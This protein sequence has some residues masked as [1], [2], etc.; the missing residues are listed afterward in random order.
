[1]IQNV[2]RQQADVA[3]SREVE[4]TANISDEPINLE[5][6]PDLLNVALANLLQNAIQASHPGGRVDIGAQASDTDVQISISD[7]GT[8]IVPEH[9]E[10]IFNPFFTTKPDG[11]GLGLAIV[12]K[13]IDEHQGRI[14]VESVKGS[15]TTF[16]I[17]LPKVQAA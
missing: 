7:Q 14:S 15:G 6:D 1:V 4:V 16:L 12:S 8:G 3:R 11:V 13:I 5:C 17:R 9:L 2:I 10:N